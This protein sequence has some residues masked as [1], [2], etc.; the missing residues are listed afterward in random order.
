MSLTTLIFRALFLPSQVAF[1]GEDNL[2]GPT[3]RFSPQR[4]IRYPTRERKGSNVL[5]LEEHSSESGA[6]N[7]TEYVL[8]IRKPPATNLSD[9]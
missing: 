2:G 9:H 1:M 8:I 3:P 5:G 6:A 7:K 4:Q